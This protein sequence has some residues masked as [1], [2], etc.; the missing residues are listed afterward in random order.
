MN[1]TTLRVTCKKRLSYKT[2][3]S[4][5]RKHITSNHP[6]VSLKK[7]EVRME[8]M[9][10]QNSAS[11][12]ITSKSLSELTVQRNGENSLEHP[13]C[14]TFQQKPTLQQKNLIGYLPKKIGK[15]A[16]NEITKKLLLLFILDFQSFRIVEDKGFQEFVYA[17]NPSYQLPNRQK[18]S[19]TLIPARYEECLYQCRQLAS[20]IKKIC[21]T[22]LDIGE[23]GKFYCCY[24]TFYR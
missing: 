8:V 10:Q 1:S 12:S 14:S 7:S 5:L 22:L 3:N 17:L 23:Y 19:K 20:N 6:T 13:S 4:N 18:I 9:L 24:W 15:S 2:T 21:F 11:S 16:V